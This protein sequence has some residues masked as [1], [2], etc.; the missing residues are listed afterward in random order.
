MCREVFP[1]EPNLLS[2]IADGRGQ[3]RAIEHEYEM[4]VEGDIRRRGGDDARCTVPLMSRE[5]AMRSVH[6]V[7]G[8]SQFA[9]L[10]CM[11]M[12]PRWNHS[13]CLSST[14]KT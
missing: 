3:D 13:D 12:C 8:V 10:D 6:V 7:A 9:L 2:S 5:T 1:R 11:H 14:T 4:E